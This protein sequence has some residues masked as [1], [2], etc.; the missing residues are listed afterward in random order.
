MNKQSSEI[1]QVLQVVA[2]GTQRVVPPHAPPG[3]CWTSIDN[4]RAWRFERREN[5][6]T[7][8]LQKAFRMQTK[9]TA[10]EL[11]QQLNKIRHHVIGVTEYPDQKRMVKY[12]PVMIQLHRDLNC[13]AEYGALNQT[14]IDLLDEL[15]DVAKRTNG[16]YCLEQ[17]FKEPVVPQVKVC[18][19]NMPCFRLY[20]RLTNMY[21]SIGH[22]VP[23]RYLFGEPAEVWLKGMAENMDDPEYYVELECLTPNLCKTL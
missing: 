12:L 18:E 11:F 21:C 3:F 4:G 8:T 13:I 17:M 5:N 7:P 16:F 20:E 2:T 22:G 6:I 10:H 19:N 23:Y 9:P 14:W 1:D 15:I